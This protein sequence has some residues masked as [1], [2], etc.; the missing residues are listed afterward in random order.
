[1]KRKPK[2]GKKRK[3]VLEKRG[4]GAAKEVSQGGREKMD[5]DRQSAK[6]NIG[7]K[8]EARQM[9]HGRN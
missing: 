2:K 9:R 5:K 4:T 7:E 8:R 3:R 6:Q 1:M